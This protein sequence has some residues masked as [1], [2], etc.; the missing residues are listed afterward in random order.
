MVREP[1]LSSGAT[2]SPPH[3]RPADLTERSVRDAR[4]AAWVYV[5]RLIC[6]DEACAEQALAEAQTLEELETLVCDCRCALVVIGWPDDLDDSV[7]QGVVV[8]FDLGL[9]SPDLVAC[10]V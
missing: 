9:A 7:G 5:A 3:A 8:S 6:S 4:H 1:P 2:G 10:C